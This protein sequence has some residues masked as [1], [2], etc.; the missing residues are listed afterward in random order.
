MTGVKFVI[1]KHIR[2]ATSMSE[3]IPVRLVMTFLPRDKQLLHDKYNSF[4]MERSHDVA[5]LLVRPPYPTE[6]SWQKNGL[7]V[8]KAK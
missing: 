3:G 4:F 7:I 6:V 5:L 8:N 2:R 1:N